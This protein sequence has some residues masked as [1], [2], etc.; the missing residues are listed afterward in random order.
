[1]LKV[2]PFVCPRRQFIC[3]A[4]SRWMN[5]F[6]IGTNVMMCLRTPT[7][8]SSLFVGMNLMPSVSDTIPFTFA[9]FL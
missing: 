9:I 3:V 6:V 5:G 8:L 1:V 7:R 2:T 4:V